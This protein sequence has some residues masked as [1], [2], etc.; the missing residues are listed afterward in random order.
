MKASTASG[1]H[2]VNVREVYSEAEYNPSA[3]DVST[4]FTQSFFYGEWQKRVGR[5]VR[6]FVIDEY[7]DHDIH[8]RVIGAFQIIIF[9][10]PFKKKIAYVPYGPVFTHAPSSNVCAQ[11]KI[12]LK[13]I[14]RE[15]RVLCVRLDMSVAKEFDIKDC[16]PFFTTAPRSTYHASFLQPRHE[17][18]INMLQSQDD[19]LRDM[20]K[21][22]RYSIRVTEKKGVTTQIIDSHLSA[23]LET[24]YTILAETAARDGF[25]LHPKT[26]YEQMCAVCEQYNS[27]VLVLSSYQGKVLAAHFV[28]LYGDTAML[29][30]AGTSNE[31]RDVMPAYAAQWATMTY[32]QTRTIG[33][34]Q[35]CWYNMGGIS[36]VHDPVSTWTGITAFKKRFGGNELVHAPFFDVVAQP[37]WYWVYTIYK[38]I[39]K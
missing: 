8:P 13:N 38:L 30:F 20:H 4:S 27:G 31:H 3:L 9:S 1:S 33:S 16:A 25:Y 24:L 7:L 28:I 22:V 10:L 26:Y 17:W 35:I 18:R 6:R 5:R 37:F 11:L 19:L 2:R 23:H 15:E 36:S 21:N 32:L 14:A 34:H 39:K 12:F 29:A